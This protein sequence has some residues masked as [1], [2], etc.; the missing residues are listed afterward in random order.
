MS[1]TTSDSQSTKIGRGTDKA[2][3]S[4]PITV[5]SGL[6]LGGP[7]G[8][9][10]T[11]SPPPR[12]SKLEAQLYYDGLPSKPRLIARTGPL[13]EAPSGPEAYSRLKELKIPG[14]HEIFEVWEDNL[15]FKA[16]A[17]LDQND[18]DWSS[19]EIVRIGYVDE[20]S[21]NVILWVGVWRPDPRRGSTPLSYDV[22]INVAL[23]CKKLLEH[24]GIM[25]VNVELRESDIIQSVGPQLLEPT[26]SRIDPTAI[27]REPFTATLGLTICAKPTPWAEGTGGFF[28]EVDDGN[29]K[30][31]LFLVTAR[32]VVF[33]QSD[34]SLFERRSESQPRHN[35][36]LLSESSFQQHLVSIKNDIDEQTYMID[37]QKTQMDELA[38][39]E[40]AT[41]IAVR[42]DAQGLVKKAEA[43]VQALTNFKRELSTHWSTD[44]SR[45]LGHVIFSPPIVVGA[46]TEQQQYTQDVA[47]IAI[48]TSKIEPNR[49]AGN[50]IDLGTKYSP[51][52]LSRMMHPNLKNSHNF[53]FPGNRL[54]KLWGTIEEDEMRKPKMYDQNGDACIMVLKRGRTTGLTVGRATTF[55]SY[56]RYYFSDNDTAVSK[57]LTILSFDKSSGAF[58]AKGDSGSAVVDGAGRVVGILTGGGGATDSTDVT[59]VTPIYFVME[60]IRRYKPLANAYLKSVQPA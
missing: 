38:G 28:L 39:L 23:K 3:T 45:T 10:A 29:G 14:D 6:T 26:Y 57:E 32:H 51:Y 44:T 24:Y 40:D 25:D 59:Y 52:A 41:T 2:V 21:G 20:P 35:V 11:P 8:T 55:V 37:H 36:L 15:A 31:S 30:K 22:A 34:N 7:A 27:L 56:T 5:M 13:W 54:L 17:I 1:S 49:F 60:V 4:S 48:D 42:E 47:V 53:K 46:G 12:I 33:P 58:S 16:H 19:T 18:V 43:N 50:V 9:R